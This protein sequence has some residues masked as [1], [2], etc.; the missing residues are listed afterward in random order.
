M[1]LLNRIKVMFKSTSDE[2]IIGYS[3]VELKS[4]FGA[5]LS[6]ADFPKYHYPSFSFLTS[7]GVQAYYSNFVI[8]RDDVNE[9]LGLLDKSFSLAG[10]RKFNDLSVELYSGKHGDEKL[11]LCISYKEFNVATIRLITNS[12]DFLSL[13]GERKFSVPP[14]WVAFEGYDPSWWGGDMQGAQGY[15]NDNYFFSFF[16]SLSLEAREGYYK[17]YLA[18]DAWARSLELTLSL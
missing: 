15:Y 6:E 11:I 14:P 3:I 4:I 2:Q 12:I 16:S 18:T 17:R 1:S 5:F 10:E 7:V 8:D 13:I 9:F